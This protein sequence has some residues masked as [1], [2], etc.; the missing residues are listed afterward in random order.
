M[1]F[2]TDVCRP[3]VHDYPSPFCQ[4]LTLC[5]SLKTACESARRIGRGDAFDEIVH[6]RASFG[7]PNVRTRSKVSEKRGPTVTDCE[8][9]ESVCAP[10]DRARRLLPRPKRREVVARRAVAWI[11]SRAERVER[12]MASTFDRACLIHSS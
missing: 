4:K 2:W 11:S 5:P 9:S 12:W 3:S 6:E 7:E 10:E 1:P 8:G